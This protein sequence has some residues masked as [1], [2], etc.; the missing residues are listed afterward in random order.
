MA[1]LWLLINFLKIV[2]QWRKTIAAVTTE[3]KTSQ[4][5]PAAVSACWLLLR[6]CNYFDEL[7]KGAT[8]R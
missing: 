4:C 6:Y 7:H 8:K 3:L 1:I 5:S 2:I